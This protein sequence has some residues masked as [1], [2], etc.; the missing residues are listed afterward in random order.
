MGVLQRKRCNKMRRLLIG[1][2]YDDIDGKTRRVVEDHLKECRSCS[3]Y[4]E[5]LKQLLATMDLRERYEPDETFWEGY[6]D[7]LVTRMERE[8][9][10]PR[11][12]FLEKIKKY[13]IVTHAYRWAAGL[14]IL[15]IGILIGKYFFSN[16]GVNREVVPDMTLQVQK[17]LERSKVLL[18]GLMNS[19]PAIDQKIDLS[20]ERRVSRALIKQA[21]FLKE[22]LKERRLKELIDDLEN[23]LVEIANM[24]DQEDLPNVEVLREGIDRRGILLKINIYE[25]KTSSLVLKQPQG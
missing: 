23:I 2:I 8:T 6:W 1:L 14:A 19:E 21:S 9:T 22:N 20:K 15:L 3:T 17:Y 7:R 25:M 16:K 11:E 10:V 12:G 13:L 24:E 18:L 4:L 5:Q